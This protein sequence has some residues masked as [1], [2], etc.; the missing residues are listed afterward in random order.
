MFRHWPWQVHPHICTHCKR[1]YYSK[2]SLETHILSKFHRQQVQYAQKSSEPKYY[3]LVFAEHWMNTTVEWGL[4]STTHL[5]R[6]RNLKK[7]MTDDIDPAKIKHPTYVPVSPRGSDAATPI[8]DDDTLDAEY[9]MMMQLH[10][11][12]HIPTPL[13][14][15]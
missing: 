3:A 14:T 11:E 15:E 6:L 1:G 10:P 8:H 9:L 5:Q 4:I 13:T 7:L 12:G 2:Y